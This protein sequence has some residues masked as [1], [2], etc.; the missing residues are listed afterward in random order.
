MAV[1]RAGQLG[2]RLRDPFRRQESRRWRREARRLREVLHRVA[3]APQFNAALATPF[4][5]QEGRRALFAA[6]CEA[7]SPAGLIE[8]GT[9]L[10]DTAGYMAS[11]TGAPVWS[12][13]LDP[14][15]AALARFRLRAFGEQVR[16]VHADSRSFLRELAATFPAGLRSFFTWTRTG[17]RTYRSS[18]RSAPSLASGTILS[19]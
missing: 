9:W 14:D 10:G 8:T 13:E 19:C 18:A 7:W 17:T 2:R 1:R 3:L 11:H 4:N 6:L 15:F 5:G 16:V 12:C